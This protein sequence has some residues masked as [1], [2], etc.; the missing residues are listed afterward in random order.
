[1]KVELRAAGALGGSH[2]HRQ[3]LGSTPGQDGVDGS[4]LDGQST[5]VRRHLPERLVAR[6]SGAD[7][8]ALDT[9]PGRRH[10]RKPVGYA[11]SNQTSNS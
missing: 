11:F 8:H 7:E 5:V 4:L 9:L 1:M 10:D 6:P 2:H 3:I